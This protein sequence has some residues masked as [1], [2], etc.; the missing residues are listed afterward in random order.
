M[1]KKITTLQE[2]QYWIALINIF[3]INPSRKDTSNHFLFDVEEY[4]APHKWKAYHAGIKLYSMLNSDSNKVII[5]TTKWA[6]YVHS[7]VYSIH[8]LSMELLEQ[9]AQLRFCKHI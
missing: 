3:I 8:F 4:T 5:H 2:Y 9:L 6:Q 1:W 7:M